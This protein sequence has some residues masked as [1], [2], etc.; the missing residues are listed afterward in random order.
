[1][2]MWRTL[3]YHTSEGF[4]RWRIYEDEVAYI[5]GGNYRLRENAEASMADTKA[6]LAAV[7][8]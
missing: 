8:K 6:W 5:V 4:W 7:T 2:P 1:M 3:V